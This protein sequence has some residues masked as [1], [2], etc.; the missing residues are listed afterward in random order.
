MREEITF[1]AS[2]GAQ[3]RDETAEIHDPIVH[4]FLFG[5][6]EVEWLTPSIAPLAWNSRTSARSLFKLLLCAPG[7]QAPKAQLAGLLWPESPEDRARESLRSASKILAKVLT[8]V[9]GERL[10]DTSQ[11]DRLKLADQSHIWADIDAFELF[12]SSAEHTPDP[13]KAVVY[14]QQARN[15]LRGELLAEDRLQQWATYQWIKKRRQA[16]WLGRCRMVRNLSDTHLRLGQ[17]ASAEEILEAHLVRFPTDQDAL[18]RLLVLLVQ[19]GCPDEAFQ[20]YE[21]TRRSLLAQGKK[22]A[23]HIDLFMADIPKKTVRITFLKEQG[24]MSVREE[25]EK[26][27]GYERVPSQSLPD[28]S[29]SQLSLTLSHRPEQSQ[30]HVQQLFAE[31]IH[32]GGSFQYMDASRRQL[33]GGF[34]A[35]IGAN[36]IPLDWWEHLGQQNAPSL[37]EEE[38]H[39]F[40]QLIENGWGLC[41]AGEWGLAEY[42]LSSFLP[43][44]ILKASK[45]KEA[46]R[47]AAQGLVLR[48]ILQAHQLNVSAMIPLCRHATTYAKFSGDVSIICAALNGLAVAYKYNQ[49][50]EQSFQTYLEALGFCQEAAPLIRS[51]IYAGAA[52]AFAHKGRKQ[53][54]ERY[55]DMGYS[56]FPQ[57]PHDDP[58][59]LSADH[60]IYMLAYYQ[61]I[62]YLDLE[63]PKLALQAFDGY[64]TAV[65]PNDVPKR[66]QLEIL[67]H[68]G[69]AAIGAKNL[70]SYVHCLK[71]GLAGAIALKSQKRRDE[72]ITIFQRDVP[73]AWQYEKSLRHIGEQYPFLQETE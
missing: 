65:S 31:A 44:V 71:E 5:S 35:L 26:E 69:R 17:S 56:C 54:M 72:V 27:S 29:R 18:F 46:A 22:T 33:L 10:L 39:Y 11:R 12:V 2:T 21:R 14:W 8:T 4:V 63:E 15:L 58:H 1:H 28:A 36:T 37:T 60:G 51:R 6:F 41:N 64:H 24:Q 61:G 42:M 32:Q 38:G 16:L 67:N 57:N 52:A 7:R 68:K 70:D 19:R 43:E 30:E 3:D 49:Q 48:S 45:N 66:N 9:T 59:F 62:A 40:Q 13:Q 34:L 23:Q 25:I 55:I 20:L 50:A 47:L 73:V 53:E